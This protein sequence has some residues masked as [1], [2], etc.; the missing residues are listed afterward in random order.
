[1][2][3]A[4]PEVYLYTKL[5][6]FLLLIVLLMLEFKT[7]FQYD[8]SVTIVEHS[9]VTLTTANFDLFYLYFQKRIQK[10]SFGH[11]SESLPNLNLKLYL[12]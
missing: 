12:P 1:M 7:H 10:R 6:V 8:P 11:L 5:C 2:Y 4:I 3:D 9:N